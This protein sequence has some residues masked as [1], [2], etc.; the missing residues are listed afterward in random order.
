[1][2]HMAICL[3]EGCLWVTSALLSYTPHQPPSSTSSIS[4]SVP[5]FRTKQLVILFSCLASQAASGDGV[6]RASPIVS[7]PWLVFFTGLEEK[8]WWPDHAAGTAEVASFLCLC[9]GVSPFMC[10]PAHCLRKEAGGDWSLQ[11]LVHMTDHSPQADPANVHTSHF[12]FI[13]FILK[14]DLQRSFRNNTKNY[15]ISFTHIPQVLTFNLFALSYT[16]SHTYTYCIITF[17]WKHLRVNC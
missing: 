14:S 11:C 10:N 4:K 13:H 12:F 7:E 3:H 9:L 1:M 5:F 15:F 16:L 17:F 6:G 2:V 8:P